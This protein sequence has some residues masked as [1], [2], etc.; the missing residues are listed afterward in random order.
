M[1]SRSSNHGDRRKALRIGMIGG[2]VV[3]GGVYE[4]IGRLGSIS[5]NNSAARLCII[6]KLCVRDASKVRDFTIDTSVTEVVTD[7]HSILEDDTI[8]LVI[9]AMGG[10]TTAKMIVEECLKRKKAV[11]T[12]NKDLVA[13]HVDSLQALAKK[14]GSILAYEAAVCGGIPIIQTL[15][16]CYTGDVITE[17]VGVCNGTT[18]YMLSKMEEQGCDYNDVLREVQ[19]LGYYTTTQ[20]IDPSSDVATLCLL[21]KLAF[22]TTV[23]VDQV[24]CRGIEDITQVDFEYAKLLGCTIK[25]VGTAKRLPKNGQ[26]DGPLSVYVIPAM[27]P[28]THVLAGG[29]QINKNNGN[30]IAISSVNMGTCSYT[31]PGAGRFATANSIVSDVVRI[32]NGQASIDPFPVT[33]SHLELDPNYVSSHYVRIPYQDT[34]GIVGT[35]GQLAAEYGISINS[36]LQNAILDKREADFCITTDECTTQQIQG[37]CEAVAEQEFCRSL[38]LSMP[39]GMT[40]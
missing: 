34:L 33:S 17:I 13:G 39:L 29:A 3:G 8:D 30:I 7:V 14:N 6:T 27:I 12:A 36:V 37:F 28:K 16:S 11:V 18:N 38:P 2:G 20:T 40:L 15:Q 31:G 25:L 23:L 1:Y 4:L 9:E 35:I 19:D 32:A 24:P 26:Y 10:T 21:A 22:G 5:S